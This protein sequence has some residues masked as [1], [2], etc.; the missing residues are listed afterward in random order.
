LAHN[1]IAAGFNPSAALDFLARRQHRRLGGAMNESMGTADSSDRADIVLERR[2]WD[3]AIA[4]ALVL[5]AA[6]LVLYLLMA[7]SY[8]SGV[9]EGLSMLPVTEVHHE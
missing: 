6:A 5:G 3:N 8:Y 9:L 1:P 4:L 2:S 7:N